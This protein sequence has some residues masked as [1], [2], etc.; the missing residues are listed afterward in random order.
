MI[1]RI[2]K[3]S[4]LLISSFCVFNACTHDTINI[5]LLKS[6]TCDPD[7]VYF[8]NDVLPLVQ[9]SCA[10][11]GCH[12][13]ETAKHRVV[14]N[15][16][17][18]IISTGKIKKGDALDS[19]LY[20]VLNEKGDDMMAPEDHGGPWDA[21]K[22]EMIKTWINQGALNN[23]C[24]ESACDTNAVTFSGSVQPILATYC[25]GCHSYPS[26]EGGVFLNDYAGVLD[27]VNNKRILGSI[28]HKAGFSAMPKNMNKLSDCEI[29]TVAIWIE[30]GALNN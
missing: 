10:I 14:L 15:N 28:R 6:S 12:D 1:A 22:I 18:N 13:E 19:E 20:E 3:R 2:F 9:S 25:L 21:S 30:N 11:S 16:Y 17:E 7:T 8:V 5:D 29:R 4:V 24:Q 23:Q 26:P 27:Q